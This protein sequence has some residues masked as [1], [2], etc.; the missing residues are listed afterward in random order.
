VPPVLLI[1][2]DKVI[3]SILIVEQ[4]I[5]TALSVDSRRFTSSSRLE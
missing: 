5:T 4:N 1:V 3:G 2:A